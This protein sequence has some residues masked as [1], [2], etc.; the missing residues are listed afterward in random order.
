MVRLKGSKN[1][2]IEDAEEEA[3]SHRE[4]SYDIQPNN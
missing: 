1:S 2:V 4:D 3:Y